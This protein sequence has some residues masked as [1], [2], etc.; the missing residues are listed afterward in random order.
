MSVTLDEDLE[1][2]GKSL[3]RKWYSS[4]YKAVLKHPVLSQHMLEQVAIRFEGNVPILL[5][6]KLLP[7]YERRMQLLLLLSVGI[8][9]S[10][11][12]KSKL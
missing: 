3:A 6:P 5:A 1:P 12:G 11:N 2:I 4:F 10:K 9:W 8:T 7:L